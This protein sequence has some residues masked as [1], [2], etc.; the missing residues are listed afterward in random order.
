MDGYR[1]PALDIREFR[2]ADGEVIPYGH[3][4]PGHP[5]DETYSVTAHPE[6]FA[7]LLEVARSLARALPPANRPGGDGILI[8]IVETPFPGVI[9]NIGDL[10]FPFPHCGCDACDEGVEE[11][12]SRMEELVDAVVDNRFEVTATGHYYWG[13]WGS[14][15]AGSA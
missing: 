13:E 5:A 15:R 8:D 14:Y 3:R 2:G 9:V 11:V 12:A 10:E 4:W 6:R 1:R 7:P